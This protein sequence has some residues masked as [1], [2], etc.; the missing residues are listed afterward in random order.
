[1][2]GGGL[3]SLPFPPSLSPCAWFRSASIISPPLPTAAAAAAAPRG[4]RDGGAA[5]READAP[6]A[7]VAAPEHGGVAEHVGDD[8][9]ADVGAADVDLVEVGDAAVAGRHGDV[10]ELDVHV[11]LGCAES[12]L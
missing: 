7:D 10:L 3:R 8:E 6:A 5:A 2:K 12:D 9:V 4:P 11:V 1:M